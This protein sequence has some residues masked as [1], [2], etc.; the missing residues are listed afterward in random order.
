MRQIRK[1]KIRVNALAEHIERDRNDVEITRALAV[2]EQTAF[3]AV[4]AR[5]KRKL[6]TRH[7]C[8]AVVVAMR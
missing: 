8:T 1:I 2:A 3:H 6:A 4:S 7:A 5:Q